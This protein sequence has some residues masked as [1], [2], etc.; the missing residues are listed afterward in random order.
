MFNGA[1]YLFRTALLFE[2]EPSLYGERVEMYRMP[3]PY[4]HNID[5]EQDWA[6]AERLLSAPA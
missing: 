4:G 1:I 2:R 6:A 5:D 3:A